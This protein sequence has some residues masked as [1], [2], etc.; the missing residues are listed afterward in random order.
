MIGIL[1]KTRQI[2]IVWKKNFIF[3][4]WEFHSNLRSLVKFLLFDAAVAIVI[5]AAWACSSW[6][7][8][9]EMLF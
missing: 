5:C 4:D 1:H 3:Y 7:T 8:S 6:G 2:D 9:N